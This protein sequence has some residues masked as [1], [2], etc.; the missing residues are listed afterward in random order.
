[1]VPNNSSNCTY[2]SIS[3]CTYKIVTKM[4]N[5][6]KFN[7]E[8]QAL[9]IVEDYYVYLNLTFGAKYSDAILAA[10][11]SVEKVIEAMQGMKVT[12]SQQK[13]IEQWREVLQAVR[14]L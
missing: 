8:E 1:M 4:K 2:G 5:T 13:S 3:N 9:Q 11:V 6:E 7:P 14:D 10:E 12:K